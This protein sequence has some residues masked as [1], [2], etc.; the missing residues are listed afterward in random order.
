MVLLYKKSFLYPALLFITCLSGAVILEQP[1]LLLAPFVLA[2]LFFCTLRIKSLWLLLLF[3]LPVSFEFHFTDVLG[4]DLPDEPVMILLTCV[5]FGL[6]IA[7]QLRL[8]SGYYNHPV[9]FVLLLG[10]FW[11]FASMCFSDEPLIS[12]K[13]LLAKTWYIVPFCVLPWFF[14]HTKNDIRIFSGLIAAGMLVT[15]ISTIIQ[16]AQLGFLFDNINTAVS[17]FFRNHVTYSAMLVCSIPILFGFF[18]LAKNKIQKKYLLFLL[19]L[20]FAALFFSYSRGAWL[21]KLLG[22]VSVF[23]IRKKLLAA[24]FILSMIVILVIIFSLGYENRYLN[25]HGNY[26]KTIY[27]ANFND[28][29]QATFSGTD[30]SNAERL[31]RWIAAIRMRNEHPVTGFGPNSFYNEYKPFM[32]SYFKTWVSENKERSTVHNYFLLLLT[33]QGWVGLLLFFLLL[34]SV[35]KR[36]EILYHAIN[37]PFYK[38]VLLCT[39]SIFTMIITLNMLSDLLETDKI[40]SLFYLCIGFII[41]IDVQHRKK[42][43]E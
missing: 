15:V 18:R 16:H 13:Y 4:M 36:L 35:L 25:Y 21:A 22:A 2:F 8:S 43:I 28:H 31:N 1:L 6:L 7:G 33:E 42:A 37:D 10:F 20:F 19:L 11:A 29:L 17:P 39:G 32:V 30:L 24:G 14:L 38:I 27:H 9:F 34:F 5:F 3:L 12:L 41:W 23:L 40:G 26:K